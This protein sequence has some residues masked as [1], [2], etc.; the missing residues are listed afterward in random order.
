M[1]DCQVKVVHRGS[2]QQNSKSNI[3]LRNLYQIIKPTLILF[4]LIGK[5]KE[6]N[7][8]QKILKPFWSLKPIRNINHWNTGLIWY[9]VPDCINTFQNSIPRWR[10][11]RW[12]FIWRH[13]QRI[14]ENFEPLPRL[15][16]KRKICKTQKVTRESGQFTDCRIQGRNF[17]KSCSKSSR[18][19][20]WGHWLR[21][22]HSG[23]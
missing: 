22:I 20:C 11:C 17:G 12:N 9:S 16:A 15:S 3:A 8:Q 23:T 2:S 21:K 19:C 14:S 10:L 4:I 1:E 5:H 7:G 13:G 18:H 6:L